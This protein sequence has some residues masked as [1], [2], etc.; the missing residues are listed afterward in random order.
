MHPW[1]KMVDAI[2]VSSV[3]LRDVFARHGYEAQVIRNVI[4][5]EQFRYRRR[6]P[7]AAGIS[8]RTEF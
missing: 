5:T 3:F 1:L 6:D 4:D 8:V 2:I 7:P